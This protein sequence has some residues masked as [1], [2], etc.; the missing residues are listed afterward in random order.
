MSE[1]LRYTQMSFAG[2]MNQQVD[3]SRLAANEYS[4]LINARSRHDIIEPVTL[5]VNITPRGLN[6]VQGVYSAGSLVVCFGDGLA[7]YRDENL[8]TPT[9]IK[10]DGFAMSATVDVIYATAVP[11]SVQNMSR[12]L[13]GTNN[14]ATNAVTLIGAASSSPQC[15]VVQDGVNQPMLILSNG[16]VRIAQNYN[17][18]SAAN[19]EYVP[20][21]KQMLYSGGILYIV[22]SDGLQIFRSVTGRPLDFCVAVDT[23]AN[24][25]GEASAVSHKVDYSPITCIASLNSP[26]GSF[27][28]STARTSY[29]VTPDTQNLIFGEPTFVNNFLFTTGAKTQFSV[30]D[31]LGDM[32]LVD[33]TAIRSFNSVQQAKFDGKNTPFSARVSRLFSDVK[34]TSPAAITFDN[35]GIFAVDTQYGKG[36]MVYDTLRGVWDSVDF[37]PALT[38]LDALMFAEVKTTVNRRLIFATTTDVFELY[39]DVADKAR[40]Y[41]YTAEYC[42]NDATVNQQFNRVSLSFVDVLSSGN[43]VIYLVPDGKVDN[44]F[45]LKIK[46]E[47]KN[48]N[49]RNSLPVQYANIQ[50]VRVCSSLVVDTAKLCWKCGLGIT[51]AFDG[52]LAGIRIAANT[53]TTTTPVDQQMQQE[54]TG[55]AYVIDYYEFYGVSAGSHVHIYGSGN[56]DVSV[57]TINGKTVQVV[58]VTDTYIDVVLPPDWPTG[59]PPINITVT[60]TNDTSYTFSHDTV[61]G[62]NT[63][64]PMDPTEPQPC[65]GSININK[66]KYFPWLDVYILDVTGFTVGNI[67]GAATYAGLMF[68][69]NTD[70]S[71]TFLTPLWCGPF[72]SNVFVQQPV[73]GLL[74]QNFS[75]GTIAFSWQTYSFCVDFQHGDDWKDHGDHGDGGDGTVDPC[76]SSY[77]ATI[78]IDHV[79]IDTSL[80]SGQIVLKKITNNYKA[81]YYGSGSVPTDGGIFGNFDV[82]ISKSGD[83]WTT[84]VTG[85]SNYILGVVMTN[86]SLGSCLSCLPVPSGLVQLFY[87]GGYDGEYTIL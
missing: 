39:S 32:A 42:S 5:P 50:K 20:I 2:G 10:L 17:E 51:W 49:Y 40:P 46:A 69:K 15:L 76:D 14:S 23:N 41:L 37:F 52:K 1:P 38:G 48:A 75:V 54:T 3:G 45:K 78:T 87:F 26:D 55:E 59:E 83:V 60:T 67:S 30:T 9:W 73:E 6:K 31:I 34:Q 25:A 43:T 24:K 56:S 27:F 71:W 61:I 64:L 28:V 84:K 81:A 79:V 57:I 19:R 33:Y 86:D 62:D 12:A 70:G 11:A 68:K 35:Y 82:V 85:T 53:D 47:A 66:A 29:S 7:F 74:N 80:A 13:S 8:S 18:W 4:L 44:S 65:A 72:M 63:K 21:G 16:S 58:N 77:P 22:S 36:L